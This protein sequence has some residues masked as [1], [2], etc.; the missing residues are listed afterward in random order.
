MNDR[1][2]TIQDFDIYSNCRFDRLYI[3]YR[4]SIKKFIYRRRVS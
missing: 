4:E 3:L 1:I 2:F